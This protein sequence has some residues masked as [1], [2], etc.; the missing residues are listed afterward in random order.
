MAFEKTLSLVGTVADL[1]RSCHL[2]EIQPWPFLSGSRQR[3]LF[4]CR[5]KKVDSAH[6]E[7]G[8]FGPF[9]VPRIRSSNL[10]NRAQLWAF[11][12][13][14]DAEQQGLPE[15]CGC[16]IFALR[17]SRG[18][19]PWYV[20]RTNLQDFRHECFGY[21]KLTYFNEALGDSLRGVPELHFLARMTPKGA[22]CKPQSASDIFFLEQFLIG[23]GLGRNPEL[24][25]VAGTR[26][27]R[28]L[29]V[30]GFINPPRGKYSRAVGALKDALEP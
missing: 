23:L 14:V 18:R 22:F 15:A 11:W 8:S 2:A 24:K 12:D 17:S 20:G 9:E 1:G 10:V 13:A 4:H 28:D 25:N 27:L 26:M 6:M 16:Y 30:P 29:V 5:A 19:T 7:Y 3:D 21:H